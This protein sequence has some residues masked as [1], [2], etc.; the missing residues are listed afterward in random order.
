MRRARAESVQVA[1]APPRVTENSRQRGE[2]I[3][4]K[5]SSL[6]FLLTKNTYGHTSSFRRVTV[7]FA[8]QNL[9]FVGD[10]AQVRDRKSI[11]ASERLDTT[12]SA[13]LVSY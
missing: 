3:G 10:G 11:L 2:V 1:E 8:L 4:R 7:F 13:T 6:I 5:S 12:P 9:I